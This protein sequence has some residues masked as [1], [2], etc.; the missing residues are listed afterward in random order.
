M[1]G[2]IKPGATI[3]GTFD[4]KNQG[5]RSPG[6]P[7]DVKFY[8]SNDA[9]ILESDDYLAY[10]LTIPAADIIAPGTTRLDRYSFTLPALSPANSDPDAVPSKWDRAWKRLTANKTAYVGM[11]IDFV[12]DADSKNNSNV[13]VGQDEAIATVVLT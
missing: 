9:A 11:V 4:I 5:P 7:V 8:I 6:K 1:T 12:D 10:T 2:N 13:G 3:S